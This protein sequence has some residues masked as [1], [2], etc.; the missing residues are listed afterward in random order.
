MKFCENFNIDFSLPVDGFQ[1]PK[2]LVLK[3]CT[4]SLDSEKVH[5]NLDIENFCLIN[6]FSYNDRLDI[7]MRFNNIEKFV[8]QPFYIKCFT[9][10]TDNN[11][12]VKINEKGIVGREKVKI[13]K[14]GNMAIG[15]SY[16]FNSEKEKED[17]L[18]SDSF[19]VEFF[20]SFRNRTNI[21]GVMCRFVKIENVWEIKDANTYKLHEKWKNINSLWH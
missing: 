7:E 21:Y 3:G 16:H 19:V 14:D 20:V 11:K 13:T 15:I 1:T 10:W 6:E 2:S 4:I 9:L 8:Y 12:F 17:L 18:N 5:S